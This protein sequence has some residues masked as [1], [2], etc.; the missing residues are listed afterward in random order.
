MNATLKKLRRNIYK[1]IVGNEEYKNNRK[2]S[3]KWQ[4]KLEKSK[5][6]FA[7]ELLYR[8]LTTDKE[9]PELPKYIQKG[10]NM[11]AKKLEER[12]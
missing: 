9:I 8:I 7:N 11:L 4:C 2:N 3:Y 6:D 1:D 10:F 12:V 5:S